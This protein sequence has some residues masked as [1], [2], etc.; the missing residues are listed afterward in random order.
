MTPPGNSTTTDTTQ[1]PSTGLVI[2]NYGKSML[3]EDAAGALHRCVARR[4]LGS[5]VC[6]DR[7]NWQATGNQEGVI[8]AIAPRRSVLSRADGTDRQRP[9]AANIDQ[10]MIVAAPEPVLEPFLVDKYTVAAE[11]A[12]AAPILVIN[13][14]DLLDS[15][16]HRELDFRLADYVGTGYPVIYTSARQNS[17]LEELS[18]RLAGNTS[19]LVGQ[20]GVGK[21]SL[22]KRLLPELDIAIGRLSEASGQGRHTTTTTTLYHL[23][24]GGDLIDSPGVRDFHLGQVDPD[25][26][27]AGFR[28][29]RPHIGHCRFNNCR[30]VSEPDCAVIAAVEDGLISARRL[31]SYRKLLE[32][33][34]R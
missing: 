7:V 31:E 19:I 3:V 32:T 25:T 23:A 17:G 12:N 2:V 18:D 20:S 13:K 24:H 8:T 22:I 6:G 33:G 5:I 28:E 26:L 21:S 16:A 14:A 27:A 30:H 11:L 4:S 1:H 15:A 29:F 34:D 9:L 10:I